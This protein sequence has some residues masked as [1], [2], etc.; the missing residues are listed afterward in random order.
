M[1]L[2]AL[3]SSNRNNS[4]SESSCEQKTTE[5]KEVSASE[6]C[7]LIIRLKIVLFIR[8]LQPLYK[9]HNKYEWYFRLTVKDDQKRAVNNQK[10][11]QQNNNNDTVIHSIGSPYIP[12]PSSFE[13]R[14]N[15]IHYYKRKTHLWIYLLNNILKWSCLHKDNGIDHSLLRNQIKLLRTWKTHLCATV[16]IET[17]IKIG[18]PSFMTIYVI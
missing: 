10:L 17:E 18:K 6:C 12:V 16:F 14:R 7:F 1:K 13:K 9:S 15:I 8:W 5:A 2:L 4:T 11:F 3:A